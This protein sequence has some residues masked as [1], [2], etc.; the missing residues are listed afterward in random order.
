MKYQSIKHENE[1]V[2]REKKVGRRDEGTM[3]MDRFCGTKTNDVIRRVC[4]I[5]E[6]LHMLKKLKV[7]IF[8]EK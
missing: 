4:L 5:C 1:Y 7:K 8:I 2:Q 3:H 6:I